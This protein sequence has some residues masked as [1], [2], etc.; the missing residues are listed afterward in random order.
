M[1]VPQ[2]CSSS[3]FGPAKGDR[4]PPI[5]SFFFPSDE[6]SLH[7]NTGRTESIIGFRHWKEGVMAELMRERTVT[8]ATGYDQGR[9]AGH[10]NASQIGDSK[11]F[12]LV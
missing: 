1:L 2:H 6:R 10:A 5:G 4:L 12:V 11:P 7:R 8:E 3:R 9:I